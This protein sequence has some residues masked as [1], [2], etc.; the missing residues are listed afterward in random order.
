MTVTSRCGA[1]K[2]QVSMRS[3]IKRG[4]T[5]INEIREENDRV[6]VYECWI[7]F[8]EKR[9]KPST[10]ISTRMKKFKACPRES[11]LFTEL[12]FININERGVLCMRLFRVSAI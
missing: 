8:L 6:Y 9:Q 1:G 4:S 11:L 10:R 3:T 7:E 2:Q 12:I 5:G